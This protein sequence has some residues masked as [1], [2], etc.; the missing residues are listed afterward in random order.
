MMKEATTVCRRA[1]RVFIK[2]VIF[3]NPYS[4][5]RIVPENLLFHSCFRRSE[6][7][8]FQILH[9]YG[10]SYVY[11]RELRHSQYPWE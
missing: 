4:L 7:L 10:F 11:G 8:P 5:K 3:F 1:V 2:L 6:E 9:H